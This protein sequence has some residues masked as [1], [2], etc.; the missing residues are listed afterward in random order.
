[1]VLLAVRATRDGCEDFQNALDVH[2]WAPFNVTFASLPYLSKHRFARMV[3]IA[4]FGG[5]V[6]R[7]AQPA[8]RFWRGGSDRGT[9]Q[10]FNYRLGSNWTTSYS[11]GTLASF[12]R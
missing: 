11:I 6:E 3:N 9:R 10:F 8:N 1:M 2:F 4:S 7:L 12:C 5:K